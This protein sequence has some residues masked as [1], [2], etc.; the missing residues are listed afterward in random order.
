MTPNEILAR[1]EAPLSLR[2]RVGYVAVGLA[3]L[4]GSALISLLWA[5]EPALPP[6]TKVAFA[7]LVAIGLSWVAVAGWAVTRRTP[8][9]ARDRVIAAWLGTGAW[10]VFA[11]GSLILA[12]S[13][14]RSELPLT[15]VVVALGLMAAVNLWSARRRRRALLR[16]RENLNRLGGNE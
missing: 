15:G 3:G 8:L 6:R 2:R 4:T 9:F 12:A 7:V 10:L 5:T 13:R 14:H 1:L 16:R 11:V